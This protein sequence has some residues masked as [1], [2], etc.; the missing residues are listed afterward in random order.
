[1]VDRISPSADQHRK[2]AERRDGIKRRE[3]EAGPNASRDEDSQNFLD[4]IN[5]MNRIEG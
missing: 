2:R 3:T 5:K 1:M 4:T